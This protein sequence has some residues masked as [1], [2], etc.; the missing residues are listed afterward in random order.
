MKDIGAASSS[1]SVGW[2]AGDLRKLPF[3]VPWVTLGARL[4]NKPGATDSRGSP[5]V[6]RVDPA[7]V[8]PDQESPKNRTGLV[9][10]SKKPG[11]S[12]RLMDVM[13]PTQ[14]REMLLSRVD[15]SEVSR[16][17][18]GPGRPSSLDLLGRRRAC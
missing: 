13:T 10:A 15:S 8:A 16:K 1:R 11:S 2:S 14:V 7:A 18:G 12:M 9:W 3:F 4:P 17:R 6:T 5:V